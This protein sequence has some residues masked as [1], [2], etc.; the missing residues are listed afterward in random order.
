MFRALVSLLV[1]AAV[2]A[3]ASSASGSREIRIPLKPLPDVSVGRVEGTRAFVAVSVHGHR[4]RVYVCDGTRRRDPTI[5]VWFGRRWDGRSPVRLRRNGHTLS[6]DAVGADGR[7]TG[8]L[9]GTHAFTADPAD[10]PA[11][12]FKGHR[13]RRR[14]T[15]I[16]LPGLQKRGTMIPTRKACRFVLV[17][18]P[19][20]TQQW[21][22]ICN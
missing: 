18:G 12:L 3:C 2:A 1:L 13:G 4:L 21:V 9:D 19:N 14:E 6:I 15:W 8:R 7:I 20:G 5:S 10:A 17:T 22:S 11:G 16:V